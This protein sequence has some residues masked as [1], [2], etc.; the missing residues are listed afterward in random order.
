M[1][2][3]WCG[4]GEGGVWRVVCSPQ[5]TQGYNSQA[6]KAA[7]ML[8]YRR[9]DF[10]TYRIS[11]LWISLAPLTHDLNV[12]SGAVGRGADRVPE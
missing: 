8:C 4:H 2:R 6:P 10:T 11:K 3:A 9:T 1:L 5:H 12:C 7:I